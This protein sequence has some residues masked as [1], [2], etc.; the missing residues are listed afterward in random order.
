MA[1][2]LNIL[3]MLMEVL[4]HHKVIINKALLLNKCNINN[5]LPQR[6]P[7]VDKVVSVPVWQL[8]AVVV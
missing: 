7:A 6:A 2:S 5:N 1:V 3:Q 8:S 4:H